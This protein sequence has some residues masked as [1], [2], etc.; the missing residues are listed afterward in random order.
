[1]SDAKNPQPP[2]APDDIHK[3][4]RPEQSSYAYSRAPRA[5]ASFVGGIFEATASG[6]RE[7][8]DHLNDDNI[9]RLGIDNGVVEGAV[10][11]SGSFFEG[12]AKVSRDVYKEIKST[13]PAPAQVDYAQLAQMV[14]A[15]LRKERAPAPAQGETT[16]RKP[17]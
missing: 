9:F 10:V 7:F 17:T 1:M 14:A 13:R 6:F 8:R 12:L 3:T 15:E 5:A 16:P 2:A 11:A 4:P